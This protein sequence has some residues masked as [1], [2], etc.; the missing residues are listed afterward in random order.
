MRPKCCIVSPLAVLT[1]IKPAEASR[2]AEQLQ[3]QSTLPGVRPESWEGRTSLITL[4]NPDSWFTAE[5]LYYH[6]VDAV[7]IVHA[8]ILRIQTLIIPVKTL[9]LKGH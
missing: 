9:V 7:G 3:D 8:L 6:L 4:V 2:S 1:P 5:F